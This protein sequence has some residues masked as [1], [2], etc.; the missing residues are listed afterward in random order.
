MLTPQELGLASKLSIKAGADGIV[1][2]TGNKM[3]EEYWK[4]MG[5]EI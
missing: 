1:L 4:Y 5:N 2:F 3:S